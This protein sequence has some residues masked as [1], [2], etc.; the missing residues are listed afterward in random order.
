MTYG[1]GALPCNIG[2]IDIETEEMFFYQYLP[3]KLPGIVNPVLEERLKCFDKM[4]GKICCDFIGE[5]GLNA[6]MDCYVYLT[7]KRL[8]QTPECGFNR[9]GYHSDGFLTSD[10]NYIWY[11]S[12]PTVFNTSSFQLSS[13]DTVSL[14]EME[15]Q[16]LPENEFCFPVKSILRLN[17]FNIHRTAPNIEPGIRTFAKVS[18]SGD[19]YDLKGNSHNYLLEYNWEMKNRKIDRNIP[20]SIIGYK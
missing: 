17:Q 6:Y 5:Y 18:F 4:I 2:S 11:D 9:P 19:K 10:I 15:V 3:I 8:F 13:D 16:A 12:Q 7:A 14:T 20:Q 1:Y